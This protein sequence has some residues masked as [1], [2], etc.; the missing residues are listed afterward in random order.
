MATLTL[1]VYGLTKLEVSWHLPADQIG[2]VIALEEPTSPL[3]HDVL[4]VE[5]GTNW[6]RNCRPWLLD[7]GKSVSLQDCKEGDVFECSRR[8]RIGGES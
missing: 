3:A 6:M 8:G 1:V 4:M 2:N 7:Q 5:A